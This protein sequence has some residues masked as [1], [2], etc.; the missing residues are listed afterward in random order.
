ML[1]I[2]SFIGM[3]HGLESKLFAYCFVCL[4]ILKC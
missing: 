4:V 3:D 1:M 2:E